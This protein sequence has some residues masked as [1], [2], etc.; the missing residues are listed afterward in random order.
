MLNI[1]DLEEKRLIVAYAIVKENQQAFPEKTWRKWSIWWKD[2]FSVNGGALK[3][4]DHIFVK[5]KTKAR[6]KKQM[7][8]DI[9]EF[10]EYDDFLAE[11]CVWIN[12]W[13][14]DNYDKTVSNKANVARFKEKLLKYKEECNAKIRILFKK[15]GLYQQ[16]YKLIVQTSKKHPLLLG[17]YIILHTDK[18]D[19]REC[20]A[21]GSYEQISNW[22]KQ[23]ARIKN[24]NE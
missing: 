17:K 5:S 11:L 9:Q 10:K 22:I 16:G 14:K 15:S 2:D 3:M 6:E 20:V 12:E 7:G 8:E 19:I 1:S 18:Y 13:I 23:K 24:D 21:Q 4:Y